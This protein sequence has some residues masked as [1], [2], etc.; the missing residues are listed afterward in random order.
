MSKPVCQ[1]RRCRR[2]LRD[3]GPSLYYCS[4]H[5]ATASSFAYETS[6]RALIYGSRAV[7]QEDPTC[8]STRS[9]HPRTARARVA[10]AYPWLDVRASE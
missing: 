8:W 10:E 5:C 6:N 7:P 9:A 3:D 4:F 2:Q 1:N